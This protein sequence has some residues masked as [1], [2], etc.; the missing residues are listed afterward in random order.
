[1]NYVDPSH[2][3]RSTKDELDANCTSMAALRA[4]LLRKYLSITSE[5][6]CGGELWLP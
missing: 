6:S 1:M 4:K 2:A 3:G 5:G